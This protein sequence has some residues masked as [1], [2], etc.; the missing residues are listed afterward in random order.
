LSVVSADA[1]SAIVIL[2]CILLLNIMDMH[3][4]V[5]FFLLEVNTIENILFRNTI[6]PFLGV[7]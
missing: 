3:L 2:Y 1:I 7:G 4:K 6:L 5:P